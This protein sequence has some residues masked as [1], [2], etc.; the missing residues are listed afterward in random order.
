MVKNEIYVER[1]RR[2][3]STVSFF[4]YG[5]YRVVFS[6]NDYEGSPNHHFDIIVNHM[7]NEDNEE[8]KIDVALRDITS[9][10][11]INY[12]ETELML[13]FDLHTEFEPTKNILYT[14]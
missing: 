8:V 12:R 11:V 2:V 14:L 1:F 9:K 5:G 13:Y 4:G 7:L 6:Y 3:S 10:S